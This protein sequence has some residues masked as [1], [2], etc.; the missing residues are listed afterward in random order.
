MN[1][2]LATPIAYLKGVGPQKAQVLQDE[3]G[4]YT[5]QDLLYHFPYRYQDRSA[6]HDIALINAE[7][8]YVQLKGRLTHI[9]EI[10][11]GRQKKTTRALQRWFRIH[12][13][14]LVSGFSMDQGKSQ[15][16]GRIYCFWKA[17]VFPKQLEY[18]ASRIAQ[19]RAR[20]GTKRL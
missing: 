10:G 14:C 20:I 6:F 12:R 13:P 2:L 1:A 4:I 16:P 18:S 9:S 15:C 7:D 11:S 19:S 3:L 17:Q 8:Q 5:F